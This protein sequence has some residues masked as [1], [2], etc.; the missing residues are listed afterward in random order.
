MDL[1]RIPAIAGSSLISAVRLGCKDTP[2]LIILAKNPPMHN[3]Q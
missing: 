2:L 1:L 3:P